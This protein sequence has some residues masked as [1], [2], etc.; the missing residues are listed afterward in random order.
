MTNEYELLEM[1]QKSNTGMY[2]NGY[3]NSAVRRRPLY[4]SGKKM[5]LVN[6][7]KINAKVCKKCLGNHF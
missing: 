7:R 2:H 6:L 3:C 1:W 4:L 5:T